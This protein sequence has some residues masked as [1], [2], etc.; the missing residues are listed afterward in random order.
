MSPGCS[1]QDPEQPQVASGDLAGLLLNMLAMIEWL[2]PDSIIYF[3]NYN[4]VGQKFEEYQKFFVWDLVLG[5]EKGLVI[6]N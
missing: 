1:N 2:N 5:D 4:A 6:E 3:F